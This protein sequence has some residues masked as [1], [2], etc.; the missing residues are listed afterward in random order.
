MAEV[1]VLLSGKAERRSKVCVLNQ[2]LINWVA[3]KENGGTRRR[4]GPSGIS[5]WPSPAT[6]NTM[7]RTFFA[8]TKDYYGWDFLVKDFNFEKGYNG[9]FRLLVE[10]RQREDV[11]MYGDRCMNVPPHPTAAVILT[12]S[13]VCLSHWCVASL[14]HIPSNL[15]LSSSANLWCEE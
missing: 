10:Q 7:V 3:E 9:F 13:F 12:M 8:A 4:T 6:L 5:K 1:F 15:H 2:M 11:S 14:P